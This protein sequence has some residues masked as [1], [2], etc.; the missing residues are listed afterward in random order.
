MHLKEMFE[1]ASDD[2]ANFVLYHLG[3]AR[4]LVAHYCE[5]Y[6]VTTIQAI[7]PDSVGSQSPGTLEQEAPEAQKSTKI[8]AFRVVRSADGKSEH[9]FIP[10]NSM[11]DSAEDAGR[12]QSPIFDEMDS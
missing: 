12:R 7:N 3:H 6:H 9:G 5:K 11:P 1:Y 8:G 4:A 10:S 2:E